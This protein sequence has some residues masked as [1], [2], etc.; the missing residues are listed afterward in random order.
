M[1]YDPPGG[2]VGIKIAKLFGRAPEQQ[3]ATDLRRLKQLLETGEIATTEGQPAG[4][5]SSISQRYDK[6]VK[7]L[8]AV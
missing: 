3:V 5:R 8:A 1:Q 4:R 7:R 2:S 6:Y